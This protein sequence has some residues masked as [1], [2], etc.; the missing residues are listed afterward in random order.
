M[1]D[2]WAADI[3]GAKRAG[4]RAAY[5]RDRQ[6]GSPLPASR[7]DGS[8]VADLEVDSL[9]E[10]ESALAEARDRLIG[11]RT[12]A[13]GRRAAAARLA[14]WMEPRD[15]LLNIATLAARRSPGWQSR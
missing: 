2:D 12:A 10:L 5:L 15:R 4:W 13:A 8:V 3:V 14:Q 11:C 6:H 9:A 7:P 1:G